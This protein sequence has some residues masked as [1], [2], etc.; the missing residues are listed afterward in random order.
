MGVGLAIGIATLEPQPPVTLSDIK[1]YN[2]TI[3]GKA[4]WVLETTRT[5]HAEC[6]R[7]PLSRWFYGDDGSEWRQKPIEKSD[8]AMAGVEGESKNRVGTVQ[9]RLVFERTRKLSGRYVVYSEGVVGCDN[10]YEQPD[11]RIVL[12]APFDWRDV[13]N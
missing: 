5:Q 3:D 10:G 8:G 4:V 2:A 1:S 7:R 13:K 11:R 6:L 12:N 9:N